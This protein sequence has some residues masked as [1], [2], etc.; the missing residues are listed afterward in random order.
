[1]HKLGKVVDDKAYADLSR[2]WIDEWLLGRIIARTLQ[3]L[4]VD[5]QMAERAVGI[6]KLLTA[7]QRWF[8]FKVQPQRMA[9]SAL[10]R[11]LRDAEVQQFIQVNRY[12]GV[13]WFNQEAYEQLCDWLLLPAVVDSVL[14]LPEDEAVAQVEAR[15]QIIL[16]LLEAGE[17]SEYQ[18]EKLLEAAR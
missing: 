14:K 4:G 3:N 10:S 5:G 2:S 11:L 6:I 12:Q 7:N 18:V 9:F 1:M 15:L 13:L 17:A 8:E 16:K